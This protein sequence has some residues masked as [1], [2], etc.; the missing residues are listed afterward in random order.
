MAVELLGVVDHALGLDGDLPEFLHDRAFKL[1]GKDLVK[2]L[3]HVHDILVGLKH[4]GLPQI[5][6]ERLDDLLLLIILQ[7]VQQ[8]LLPKVV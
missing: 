3:T 4:K 6:R 1:R 2:E 5:F 8:L 7:G